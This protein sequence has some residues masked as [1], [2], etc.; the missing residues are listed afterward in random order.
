MTLAEQF[1]AEGRELTFADVVKLTLAYRHRLKCRIQS[2][3]IVCPL[4]PQH[5]N[6]FNAATPQ[7][8]DDMCSG[9]C[10][11]AAEAALDRALNSVHGL[12]RANPVRQQTTVSSQR[13]AEDRAVDDLVRKYGPKSQS[14][15]F[16]SGQAFAET[17]EDMA[18]DAIRQHGREQ[19]E[20]ARPVTNPMHDLSASS[21]PQ[22]SRQPIPMRPRQ[23]EIAVEEVPSNEY[24]PPDEPQFDAASAEEP[25]DN[26]PSNAEMAAG[27]RNHKAAVRREEA[28]IVNKFTTAAARESGKQFSAGIDALLDS[29]GV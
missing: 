14:L 10:N 8:G 9:N 18:N 2:N 28:R 26:F 21:T 27:I 13:T 17:F 15:N 11:F 29:M 5:R 24:F 6:N 22:L 12:Q 25:E 7:I 4:P 16:A 23:T 3:A 1:R 20:A 19:R